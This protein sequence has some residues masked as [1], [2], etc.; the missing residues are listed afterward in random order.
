MSAEENKALV[1]R[2]FDEVWNKNNLDV[3]DEVIAPDYINHGS[4]PGHP[5]ATREDAKKI[6]AQGRT[7]FPDVKW[8]MHRLVADGDLVAYHWT[9]EAT[10]MGEIMGL[11]PTGKHI[12]MQGMVFS[13][14]ANGKI[15]EQWRIVD[16]LSMLQQL[17]A[18][19]NPSAGQH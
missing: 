9:A 2:Y 5:T 3:I 8:E 16:N 13:R 15:V 1:R 7:A 18:I 12:T 11:K 17:G 10:H 6:E 4:I 19:P 14:I